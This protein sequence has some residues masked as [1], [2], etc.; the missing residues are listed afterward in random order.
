MVQ[1]QYQHTHFVC[2]GAC[3]YSCPCVFVG[4]SRMSDISWRALCR[5]SPGLTRLHAADC[6][7]MTD[8]SLKSMGALKNLVYLNI[9]HCSRCVYARVLSLYVR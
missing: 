9:S 4:N 2:Y 1:G 6:P 3:Y 5:S 8:S 7:R